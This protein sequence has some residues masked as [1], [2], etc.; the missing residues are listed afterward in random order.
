[1]EAI[2]TGARAIA[3]VGP[4]GAGKTTLAEALLHA[5]GAINR[6]GSVE[7]GTSLGDASPEARARG[8]S[9]ELNLSRFTFGG[10][11]YALLDCPGAG[12]LAAETDCALAVADLALVV[13][14]P[15]PDRAGLA[16]P[17]LR[18]LDARGIPHVLFVNRI[19]K[20]RGPVQALLEALQPL[21]REPLVARQMPI[22]SGG[23]VTGFVD[24]ALDRA[25]HYRE[26]GP[27]A[28]R[29]LPRNRRPGHICSNSWPT[30]T[31]RCSKPCSTTRCPTCPPSRTTL[32]RRP[33]T[34]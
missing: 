13:V 23:E 16:E 19:D 18:E 15:E 33:P 34:A 10:D 30:T 26:G 12:G 21:S 4:A 2:G 1:M 20:A 11:S 3:I 14:P 17:L 5:A 29:S 8:S 9:T 6:C 28:G 31:M 24:L 22:V 27:S 32:R 25:F 7:A